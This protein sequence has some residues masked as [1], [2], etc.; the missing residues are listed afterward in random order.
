MIGDG[1]FWL[2]RDEAFAGEV[3]SEEDV[4]VLHT[5][6]EN[7]FWFYTIIFGAPAVVLGLGLAMIHARRRGRETAKAEGL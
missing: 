5:R 4:P 6:A 2:Q 3:I 7:V 1:I